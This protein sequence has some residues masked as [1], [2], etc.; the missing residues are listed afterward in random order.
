[1]IHYAL[2]LGTIL[3]VSVLSLMYSDLD[4]LWQQ[5]LMLS[6]LKFS[7]ERTVAESVFAAVLLTVWGIILLNYP[8]FY[9]LSTL[10]FYLGLIIL[11]KSWGRKVGY[12]DWVGMEEDISSMFYAMDL[13]ER[14]MKG[15]SQHGGQ[16]TISIL[17]LDNFRSVNEKLGHVQGDLLLRAFGRILVRHL[18]PSEVATRYAGDEF[19]VIFPNSTGERAQEILD[20]VRIKMKEHNR[21]RRLERL[22]NPFSFCAGIVEYSPEYETVRDF[23][24]AAEDALYLA[25]QKGKDSSVVVKRDKRLAVRNRRYW[26]RVQIKEPL[27]EAV[28]YDLNG[29]PHRIKPGNICLGGMMFFSPIKLNQGQ[30]YDLEV[31]FSDGDRVT[32]DAKTVWYREI[33]DG[34]YQIGVFLAHLSPQQKFLLKKKLEQ[35]EHSNEQEAQA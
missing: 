35:I 26:K 20:E 32:L 18:H 22:D 2:L 10:L 1:M 6:L 28:V 30:V 8:W 13:L 5:I 17:D 25:K 21:I 29:S 23:F 24:R 33:G 16:L 15:I 34:L 19:L 27:L 11:A 3:L 7:L 31:E 4:F 14:E 12:K 9:H